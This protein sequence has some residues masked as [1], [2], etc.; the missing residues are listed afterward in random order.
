MAF[1]AND[2]FFRGRGA[3]VNTHNKFLKVK[4]VAEHIEGLDEPLLQNSKTQLFM[5]NSKSIVSKSTVPI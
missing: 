3:Q 1:E 2:D 5:E 4:Y